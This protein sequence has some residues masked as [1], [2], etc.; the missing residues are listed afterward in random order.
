MPRTTA[1]MPCRCTIFIPT[2][3]ILFLMT[4]S[5]WAQESI[6]SDRPGIGSGS[7]VIDAG[8]IQIEGGASFAD[9]DPSDQVSFG[10][11][12]LRYGLALF[13]VQAVVN[14]LVF[15]TGAADDAGFQDFGVGLKT[16]ILQNDETP[17]SLSLLT[18]LLFPTGAD[19]LT[20]DE[21][22]PA[23]TLLADYPL[24]DQVGLSS[25][26]GY[27]FGTGSA[28]DV[29]SLTVTPGF[30]LPGDNNLSGYVGYAGF[31]SDGPDQN[32]LEGGVAWLVNKNVQADLNSGILLE[33]GDFFIG[34]GIAARW[35][36]R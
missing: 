31:F 20:S 11:V 15:Q 13:E 29:F 26:V 7:R 9:S 18:T 14:S 23:F 30:A 4:G 35:V 19:F 25:N 33:N 12:L 6:S 1:S 5:T 28:N 8:I 36:T 32:F 24:S 16:P 22:I 3:L 2:L 21:T 27:A 17:L 34:V 10:Q